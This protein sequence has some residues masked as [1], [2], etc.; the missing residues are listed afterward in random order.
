MSDAEDATPERLAEEARK[1][2]CREWKPTD[3][4][5]RLVDPP[6]ILSVLTIADGAMTVASCKPMPGRWR[7]FWY[8]ALLG[9]TWE[10]KQ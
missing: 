6:P 1:W 3:P 2:D 4:G 8:W 7:R 9:W 5:W 10:A